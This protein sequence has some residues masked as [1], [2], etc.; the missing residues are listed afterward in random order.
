M[1]KVFPS[2][3]KLLHSIRL[4]GNEA[5]HSD[6]FDEEDLLDAFEVINFVFNLYNRLVQKKIVKEKSFKIKTKVSSK[7]NLFLLR[8]RLTVTGYFNL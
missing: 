8:I 2:E 7:K 1:E 6:N 3:G 4:F 5:T